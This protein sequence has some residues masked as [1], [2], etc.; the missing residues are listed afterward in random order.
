MQITRERNSL[1]IVLVLYLQVFT[2]PFHKYYQQCTDCQEIH[3]TP[4]TAQSRADNRYSYND[5][6]RSA[7]ASGGSG[8]V[9]RASRI[10]STNPQPNLDVIQTDDETIVI[11][12]VDES[13]IRDKS[14]QRKN[15][16]CDS[17]SKKQYNG[18]VPLRCVTFKRC[19]S[20]SRLSS[21]QARQLSCAIN[22][23]G[24]M[25]F[26]CPEKEERSAS[27]TDDRDDDSDESLPETTIVRSD[28]VESLDSS[29]KPVTAKPNVKIQNG[30]L[31]VTD[32]GQVGN[33]APKRIKS[34]AHC[35][36]VVKSKTGE[37]TRIIGGEEAP[38][39]A[40][41]W[42]AILM[43]QRRK[44]GKFSPECGAT[45]IADR[46]IVTAAHCV[47]EQ[48]KRQITK[49]RI[50]VRLG[51]SNLKKQNDG[52]VDFDVAA[53]LTHPKF[54]RKTF[55]NDLALIKLERKAVFNESISPACLPPSSHPG[56]KDYGKDGDTVW[57]LGYGQ[58]SYKGRTSDR[59]R[60]ADLK[61]VP[62]TKCYEA[63]VH[64]DVHITGEYLCASSE[65]FE[66]IG[67]SNS[68][69]YRELKEETSES[70]PHSSSDTSIVPEGP[71][72]GQTRKPKQQKDSCQ[73]DSGGPMMIKDKDS[74]HW[75]LLGVVS[76]GFRCASAGFPG[77]Y[78]RVSRYVDWIESNIDT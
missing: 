15:Q 74:G 24:S 27:D 77:V 76:F 4:R 33:R 5:Q 78:T 49:S 40:W 12:N 73:G 14:T 22:P 66:D 61:I 46:F 59:L 41:P 21:S 63:F 42:F 32:G 47:L 16:Y 75:Q 3:G 7:T 18:T 52:E 60:Q 20:I 36:L 17:I 72:D 34:A 64:L 29:S 54:E 37:E 71:V 69:Q 38:H 67:A 65:S 44:S 50:R 23:D 57:V 19:P 70:S 35:G 51:E 26:C 31:V 45:L 58:T 30:T 39:N 53:I 1:A 8:S 2:S 10:K 28:S 11:S 25:R 55:K 62:Q 13:A 9:R 43:V 56:T 6:S 48:G 68:E